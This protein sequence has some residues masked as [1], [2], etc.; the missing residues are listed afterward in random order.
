MKFKLSIFLFI[1][2]EAF[3]LSTAAFASDVDERLD[4]IEERLSL[5]TQK[6]MGAPVERDEGFIPASS[7]WFSPSEHCPT[8][9]KNEDGF[10]HGLTHDQIFTV[11]KRVNCDN[12]EYLIVQPPDPRSF[13]ARYIMVNRN[14]VILF[15]KDKKQSGE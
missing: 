10:S 7:T 15:E 2:L 12:Q 6:V 11:R 4:K 8:I 5:L 9:K 14:A 1:S 13:N 3:V